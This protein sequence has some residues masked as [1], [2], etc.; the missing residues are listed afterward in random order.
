MRSI[1]GYSP[2]RASPALKEIVILH[3]WVLVPDDGT[4]KYQQGPGRPEDVATEVRAGFGAAVR[5]R[6]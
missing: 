2:L 3:P 1:S 5:R 4:N 6:I